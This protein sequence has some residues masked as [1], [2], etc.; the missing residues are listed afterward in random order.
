MANL[1]TFDH[2]LNC[3]TFRHFSASNISSFT[4]WVIEAFLRYYREQP[5]GLFLSQLPIICLPAPTSII[6][7]A[8]QY[9]MT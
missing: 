2:Y 5:P 8:P 4:H 1:Q 7:D 3:S 9:A 6:I